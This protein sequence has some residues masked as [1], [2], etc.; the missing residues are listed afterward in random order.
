M[1]VYLHTCVREELFL[2]NLTDFETATGGFMLQRVWYQCLEKTNPMIR[3]ANSSV[4]LY[5]PA[6]FTI[7]LNLCFP[8]S[9]QFPE[10]VFHSH[11]EAAYSFFLHLTKKLSEQLM[12]ERSSY[13]PLLRRGFHQLLQKDKFSNAA[14]RLWAIASTERLN[15]LR[16]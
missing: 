5:R 11:F 15:L 7:C 8:F 16:I 10:D 13:L 4:G 12:G 1:I 3:L 6:E 2:I 9:I 14:T